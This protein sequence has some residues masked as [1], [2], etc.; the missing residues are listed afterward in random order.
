MV[1]WQYLASLSENLK[2]FLETLIHQQYKYSFTTV[3]DRQFEN[4]INLYVLSKPEEKESALCISLKNM[5]IIQH[6]KYKFY[7]GQCSNGPL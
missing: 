7:A 2:A 1:Q 4:Y 6:M 3:K 5:L